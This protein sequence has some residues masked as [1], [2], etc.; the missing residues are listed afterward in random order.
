LQHFGKTLKAP[1][2]PNFAKE[3]KASTE[4]EKA[5]KHNNTYTPCR[6]TLIIRRLN[7]N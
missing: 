3:L 7:S 5:R 2:Q 4:E 6:S 1:T